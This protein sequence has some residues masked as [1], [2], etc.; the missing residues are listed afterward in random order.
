MI[1]LIFG[2]GFL[3]IMLYIMYQ[4]YRFGKEGVSLDIENKA[5]KEAN[6]ALKDN[7]KHFKEIDSDVHIR[8]AD[9]RREL[10]HYFNRKR[11]SPKAE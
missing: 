8:I 4:V 1:W 2:T 11:K 6:K 9:D 3:S 10:R 5:L 7:D